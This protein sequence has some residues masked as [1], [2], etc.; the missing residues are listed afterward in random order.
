MEATA[1]AKYNKIPISP[2]KARLVVDLVRNMN[3]QEAIDTL[4]RIPQKAAFYVLKVL[5]SALGNLEY[6]ESGKKFLKRNVDIK[7]IYVNQG[8][9]LKRIQPAPQGRAHPIR[10]P[11]AHITV[12][13]S[14]TKL[15]PPLKEKPKST[16]ATTPA[17]S[18][19][20][21]DKE[22]TTKKPPHPPTLK[23][24]QVDTKGTSLKSSDA[25]NVQ[26]SDQDLH[27]TPKVKARKESQEKPLA[28]L[29]TADTAEPSGKKKEH[30]DSN[31]K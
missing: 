20:R 25:S 6:K 5:Q 17:A 8:R 22:K 26:K 3:L 13:L 9:V 23:E 28:S 11:T 15:P 18:K 10:K 30:P 19:D 14:T 24:Q 1:V 29:N 27:T 4:Q 16:K 12:L 2:R 7:T 21:V 31:Q